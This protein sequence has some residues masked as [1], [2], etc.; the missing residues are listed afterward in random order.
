MPTCQYCRTENRADATYCNH[1]GGLLVAT[2]PASAHVSPAATTRTATATGRLPEQTRLHGRY[3]TLAVI[4]QGGMAAVYKATDLRTNAIVA[5]KEMSQDGLGTEELAEALESFRFEAATLARL[6]HPNL[7]RVYES[8]SENAR[9][10]LVMDFIEGQTL[11]Q[12]QQAAGGG[13]LPEAEVLG[14]AQQLCSVLGYLHSQPQPIIFRDLK[15][16]NIMLT[17]GGQIKLIDFGIAR[18]FAPGRSRDT[19]VLGTPGFAPPEQYGKTQTDARADIYAL[20]C[21]L[22][23]LLTGYDPATTPFN[24]P[25]LR[26]R[27]PRVSPGVQQAIERATRLDRDARY[28]SMKD[29]ASD[30]LRAPQPLPKPTAPH[31]A[32]PP[33]ARAGTGAGPAAR[34]AAA[35]YAASGASMA[36]DVVVQPHV[37]DFGRLV[38]GQRGTMAVSIGGHSGARLH[39]EVV[40]LAPWL[41]V[42]PKRFDGANTIVRVTAETSRLTTMGRANS[43]LQINCDGQH[44]F[45]PVAVEVQPA[46]VAAAPRAQAPRSPRRASI[47]K[48]AVPPPPRGRSVRFA[49]S[50]AVAF[51]LSMWALELALRLLATLLP[52]T[53][54]VA[55]GVL[56]AV[57]PFAAIGALAGSGGRNWRGRA[58]TA[59]AC[60]LVGLL[61]ALA[62]SGPWLWAAGTEVLTAPVRI[63]RSTLALA[64]LLSSVGAAIGADDR[65]SRWI[66][67]TAS[68]VRRHIPIFITTSAIVLGAWVG[69]AVTQ[70]IVC[71]TPLGIVLGIAVG[72]ALA[73]PIN[74]LLRRRNRRTNRYARLRP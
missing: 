13:A 9:H 55:L 14:W 20:G 48:Y 65:F 47:S 66:L 62:I 16:A 1:C 8:F 52:L 30:L 63:P 35:A 17:P 10:Y 69:Y 49:M 56:L 74:R 37:V 22:Y 18:V 50:A 29:F 7:P 4:G 27:N 5:V 57:V 60:A 58:Q 12:R 40:P 44:L 23:Q 64:P 15:P 67:I 39:G 26:S 51:G 3:L 46:P 32:V 19:Q 73:R 6:R 25:P 45:V 72:I 36:A 38:A 11:E 34:P 33:G 28:P 54:P 59:L 42:D 21:T 2:P 53:A 41:H 43:T 31:T 24:L 71:L 68:F 61:V 70:S